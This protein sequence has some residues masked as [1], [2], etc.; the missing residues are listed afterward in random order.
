MQT[1]FNNLMK[2][3]KTMIAKKLLYGL[4]RP[5]RA[6]VVFTLVIYSLGVH[7]AWSSVLGNLAA[8]MPSGTFSQITG[9]V[10]YNR[11]GIQGGIFVPDEF[12]CGTGDFITEYA[13][14]AAY[15]PVHDVI[16]FLGQ[17]HGTCTGGQ[18]IRYTIA[19]DTWDVLSWP[20]AF[21]G[22]KNPNC[23]G[24]C[25][26]HADDQWNTVNPATGTHY[27]WFGSGTLG[28]NPNSDTWFQAGP[29]G[30]GEPHP[31]ATNTLEYFPEMGK[32]V[33][34]NG[35]YGCWSIDPVNGVNW[36]Y[37]AMGEQCYSSCAGL[38]NIFTSGDNEYNNQLVYL[39]QKHV[40]IFIIGPS[41]WKIDAN[42]TFT[43][44]ANCP[45]TCSLTDSV[46]AA[47]PVS[48]ELVLISASNP[49][50]WAYNLDTNQWRD[51]G[52]SY[53]SMFT[54]GWQPGNGNM[55]IASSL[56][57]YGVIWYAKYFPGAA[58]TNNG[59]W[60]YKHSTGTVSPS[61]PAPIVNISA[62]PTSVLSGGTSTLSWTSTNASS[63]S[64]SG[65]WSGAKALSGSESTG[66]LLA[67]NT[68]ALAC[69]GAGGSAS[70]SVTVPIT[71][72]TSP[73]TAPPSGS[74]ILLVD[75]GA[76]SSQNT[77]GLAGWSTVIKDIYTDYQN[78]G[79][80]GTTIVVGSHYAYNYQGITGSPRQFNSGD[81]IRVTWYNNSSAA[82]SFTPNVTF[83]S[84]DRIIAGT[85]TWYPMSQVT[86]P[87]LG[88]ATSEFALTSATAGSYSLVNVNVNYTNTQVIVADKIELIPAG[89]SIPS[90]FDFAVSNGGNQSVSQ[91]QAVSN[92]IAA[93]LASGTAQPL[94]FSA[95]GLPAG[96]TASFSPASCSP[97]CSS[98]VNI[99]TTGSTPG[100][101]STVTVTAT[102][103]GVTRS[104]TFTLAVSVPS[105]P[106]P[107][108]SSDFQT[109]CGAPGVVRCFNFDDNSQLGGTYGDNFG[110]FNN[111][112]LNH[113]VCG[114]NAVTLCPVI[115]QTV[116]ASGTGSLKFTILSGGSSGSAGQWFANFS[117]DLATQFGANS[118][119]YVQW[120]QRFDTN[121]VNNTWPNFRAGGEG[122]KQ[123]IIGNGDLPG[124]TPANSNSGGPC[125]SSNDGLAT[126]VQDVDQHG[127]AMMYHYIG[128]STV[129]FEGTAGNGDLSW[130]N[131]RPPPYCTYPQWLI[132]K[133]AQFPP[134]GN[135]FGYFANEWMTFKVHIKPGPLSGGMWINSVVELWIGREGQPSEKVMSV[136]GNLEAN[137]QYGKIWLLP[138][139]SNLTTDFSYPDAHTWYDDLI[140][141]AQDIADPSASLQ[142]GG[143]IP[144]APSVLVVK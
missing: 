59:T 97:S 71:A 93:T 38:P 99:S 137:D 107:T 72:S 42:G 16:R 18:F 100:G 31:T 115:D 29:R 39:P 144:T 47:D 3:V 53:P 119:F 142:G 82:V 12:G 33:F 28:Y 104:T 27:S 105:I 30:G 15:D 143:Q 46:P 116:H 4:L 60:L 20:V 44:L 50:V 74:S 81:K 134:N 83:T 51:T 7:P 66:K 70:Q 86:V 136:T 130:Q 108:G 11:H 141:S 76:T 103:G 114:Q 90:S 122:P 17:T 94:T 48:G 113:S 58:G 34:C 138:Y 89:S 36:T 101:I 95:S 19:T 112:S 63:C 1:Y 69:T 54:L 84:A 73:T 55:F 22:Q 85:G 135:C 133:A 68:F 140:I 110:Y 25:L 79:P 92:S 32:N 10:N 35:I 9:S 24:P 14:D 52:I 127:Y 111:V 129:R 80:G 45:V 37:I 56:S 23:N 65:G 2:S 61:L 126:V 78:I 75:F 64:A 13:T 67:N 132:S 57:T 96:A 77:F 6:L 49:H 121:Y 8:S 40:L 102:G 43:K 131:L 62:N 128:G 87:S 117:A 41:M 98:I 21:Y 91:G 106:P 109:R 5:L 139:I 125:R 26:S 124:C 123:A 118:E 88:I 120:R